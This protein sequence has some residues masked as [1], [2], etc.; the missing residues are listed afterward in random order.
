MG[1]IKGKKIDP[2]VC[3]LCG[4]VTKRVTTFEKHLQEEHELDVETEWLKLNPDQSQY[5]A[6]GCGEKTKWIGWKNGFTRLKKGHN[7]SIYSGLYSKEEAEAISKKRSANL[8]GKTGWS[9]GLT[10]ENDERI[11]QRAKATAAGRKQAID[12]GK[13][14]I[15]SKGLTKENDERIAN[16]AK[17]L[18]MGFKEGRIT[19]WAKG[20]SK[21]TDER[22]AKMASS[23]SLKL[24]ET[25]LR[26][27]LDEI[28]R[29]KHDEIVSRIE[30]HDTLEVVD[31]LNDYINDASK[32]INVRCKTCGGNFTSSLRQLQY[33]RCWNCNP[34]GSAAQGQI[35]KFVRNLIG[36]ENVVANDR[37]TFGGKLELDIHIPSKKFAI[38]YN[39]LYWH[40]ILFRSSD[41]HANKT[42]S[43]KEQDIRLLHIFQDD[44]EYR[45]GIVE[46]TI[47]HRLGLSKR[48]ISARSC[49]VVKLDKKAR[50]KFFD[51]SHLDGDVASKI[52]W[53]LE[54][55]GEIVY[56]LS[57]RQPFHKRYKDKL[58]VARCAAA[59]DTSVAGGMSRLVKVAKQFASS[60]PGIVGLL[61]Y[62]DSRLGGT[63]VSAYSKAGFILDST[64]SP[65]F[66]W[67]DFNKRYDRFKYR[68]NKNL[69]LSEAQVADQAG[70]VKIWGCRNFVYTLDI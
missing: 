12:E 65:R 33:G 58:E 42:T 35:D 24:K 38:E 53:G 36:S 2:I 59:L 56:A 21:K 46:S 62:V 55:K 26:Q 37:S 16:A 41:Y 1:A 30:I 5:C 60:Q 13:I 43:C 19:P 8:Q 18:K 14:K 4:F 66:W 63:T 3:H 54:Y 29:L 64:T 48:R 49:Q 11:A 69:G 51:S 70:V 34:A 47:R 45:R 57:L 32:V 25:S 44:W 7:A 17:S 28:K 22:V 52:A 67:T 20:L 6:C 31:G 23:V 39:G 40:S 68:A 27:R 10:K 9:K 15:W 50:K 61:T